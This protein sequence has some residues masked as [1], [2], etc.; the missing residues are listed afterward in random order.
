M[1]DARLKPIFPPPIIRILLAIGILYCFSGS[2]SSLSSASAA[3][4][5]IFASVSRS[6]S[7]FFA[8]NYR[9]SIRNNLFLSNF[10]CENQVSQMEN[11]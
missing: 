8:G 1:F 6:F 11:N 10:S 7:S 2:T 4:S 5:A 3:S 9:F